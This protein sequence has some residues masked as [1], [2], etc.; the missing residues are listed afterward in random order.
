MTVSA[1]VRLRITLKIAI[2]V[3]QLEAIAGTLRQY[4][5]VGTPLRWRIGNTEQEYRHRLPLLR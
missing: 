2:D 4:V 1:N 3:K 5:V